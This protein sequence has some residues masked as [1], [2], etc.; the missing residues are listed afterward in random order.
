MRFLQRKQ[1]SPNQDGSE[2]LESPTGGGTSTIEMPDIDLPDNKNTG[3]ETGKTGEEKPDPLTTGAPANKEGEEN[4]EGGENRE[5]GENKENEETVHPFQVIAERLGVE[6]NLEELEDS[7]EGI[8]SIFQKGYEAKEADLATKIEQRIEATSPF[9]AE[10]IRW[11]EANPNR[12][13]EEFILARMQAPELDPETLDKD[14]VDVHKDILYK[15]FIKQGMSEATAKRYSQMAVDA[16]TSYEDAKEIIT[17]TNA[18]NAKAKQESD[19]AAA[20]Q[21]A[22]DKAAHIRHIESQIEVV[23]K[24]VLNGITIPQT[25]VDAFIDANFMDAGNPKYPGAAQVDI[26]I[27]EMTA[28]EKNFLRYL[29]HKKF[30][31]KGLVTAR[32]TTIKMSEFL[33]GK[34]TGDKMSGGTARKVTGNSDDRSLD[35]PGS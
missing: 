16:N 32:A 23:K 3:N 28:E 21:A 29:V 17:T 33:G 19:A 2:G 31:F 34:K 25:E 27:A 18:L 5:N 20:R 12:S 13:E 24:G 26:A 6:V 35:S 22:E 8:I 1:L 10:L 9:A 4:K 14:A 11:R 15:N 7:T 30:D